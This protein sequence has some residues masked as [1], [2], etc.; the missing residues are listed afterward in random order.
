M[1]KRGLLLTTY[2]NN[3]KILI[4]LKYD[5]IE[6]VKFVNNKALLITVKRAYYFKLYLIKFDYERFCFISLIIIYQ[7][8]INKQTSNLLSKGIMKD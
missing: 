8:K 4:L 6:C 3:T 5:S 1:I 7:S 2:Q